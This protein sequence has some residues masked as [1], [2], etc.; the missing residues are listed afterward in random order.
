[1]PLALGT[2]APQVHAARSSGMVLPVI[3]LDWLNGQIIVIGATHI[4]STVFDVAN[5][6]VVALCANTNCWYTVDLSPVASA[7]AAKMMYLAAGDI[8]YE[9][10][11]FNAKISVIQATAGGFLSAIPAIQAN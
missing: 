7:G 6:R 5:D 9:Y 2:H 11:P 4:E 3:A 1:M 10:I 8:R